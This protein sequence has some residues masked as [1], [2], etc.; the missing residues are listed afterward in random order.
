[1]EGIFLGYDILF[2]AGG[3]DYHAVFNGAWR[4]H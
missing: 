2:L 3:G 1:M 4:H